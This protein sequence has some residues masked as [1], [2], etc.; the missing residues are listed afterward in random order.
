M[1]AHG[2]LYVVPDGDGHDSGLGAGRAADGGH[3][4]VWP[5]RIRA[6]HARHDIGPDG[7]GESE[8][9]RVGLGVVG[10]GHGEHDVL[11]VRRN[12]L[13]NGVARQKHNGGFAAHGEDAGGHVE[14]AAGR[15]HAQRQLQGQRQR[16]SCMSGLK[17]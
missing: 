5:G 8:E 17:L 4:P 13:T 11:L 15:V 12:G 9:T 7:H 14:E 16:R 1:R 3:Q 6:P 10:A 2:T